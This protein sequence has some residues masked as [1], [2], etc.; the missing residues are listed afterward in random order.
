MIDDLVSEVNIDFGSNGYLNE[1]WLFV[2]T[3]EKKSVVFVTLHTKPSLH[4]TE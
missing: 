1:S 4:S 3:V 2:D